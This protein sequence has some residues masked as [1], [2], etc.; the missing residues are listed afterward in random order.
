MDFKKTFSDLAQKAKKAGEKG[1]KM[2][3]AQKDIMVL[4]GQIKDLKVKM[5]DVIIQT[6]EINDEVRKM[7]SEIAEKENK[8]KGNKSKFERKATGRPTRTK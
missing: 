1:V 7:V 8:I 5:A 6:N 2:A 4:K 3:V